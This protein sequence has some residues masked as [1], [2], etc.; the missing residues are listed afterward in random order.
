M[1]WD[2]GDGNEYES[3]FSVCDYE[4]DSVREVVDLI[5]AEICGFEIFERNPNPNPPI[6]GSLKFS[7]LIV[8]GLS[9]ITCVLK[10]LSGENGC[11]PVQATPTSPKVIT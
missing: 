11:G 7:K 3:D 1:I 6:M 5:V 10:K 9:F 8:T 2:F 4:Y